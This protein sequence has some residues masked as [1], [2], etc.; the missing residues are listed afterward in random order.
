MT[1][2]MF[3][4]DTHGNGRWFEFACQVAEEYGC[5]TIM[6]LGDF[7]YWEHH[8]QGSDFLTHVQE[9]LVKHN[10]YCVW[11]DGN[12]ENHPLLRHL[13]GPGGEHHNLSPEGWWTI[14]PH[15][16]HAWRGCRWSWDGKT[17]LALGGAFSIDKQ[18]RK[19]SQEHQLEYA[20]AAHVNDPD[21][22]AWAR[23][24]AL[25]WPEETITEEDVERC[26]NPGGLVDI[27]VTHD[28]PLLTQNMLNGYRENKMKWPETEVN[29]HLLQ[30]VVNEVRPHMLV[31]G[32]WHHPNDEE[33]H[34][35]YGD[36]DKWWTTRVI[37]LDCDG[38]SASM[39]VLDLSSLKSHN[40]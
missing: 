11:V 22:H 6:Q 7:G 25:W 35:R 2:I 12:H 9:C 29:R 27:M 26:I 16:F 5:D 39:A 36:D 15:L 30:K 13:Y 19:E 32:H 17:F 24:E 14:R 8:Q 38:A 31:H 20:T 28:T 37:G 34:F 1:K 21:W 3:L 10:L 33:I 4:G 18:W 23:K 40:G